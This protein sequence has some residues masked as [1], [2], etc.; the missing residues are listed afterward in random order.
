[1]DCLKPENLLHHTVTRIDRFSGVKAGFGT[2][3]VG[4]KQILARQG[5]NGS[6]FCKCSICGNDFGPADVPYLGTF[7]R[8]RQK[9]N[10]ILCRKCAYAIS[11]HVI[12][13]DGNLYD[14]EQPY[15]KP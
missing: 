1:M 11:R 8:D 9:T 4:W 12:E 14:G 7:V 3:A 5:R 6:M 13:A 2:S 10:H 15:P